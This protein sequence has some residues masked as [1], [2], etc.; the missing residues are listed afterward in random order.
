MSAS[1]VGSL[2]L[3]GILPGLSAQLEL[4]FTLLSG[5]GLAFEAQ[6]V[7]EVQAQ[8]TAT[9]EA[10]LALGVS[11]PDVA[12]ALK[13]EGALAAIANLQLTPPGLALSAQ[14][15]ANASLALELEARLALLA[16]ILAP[17]N[18]ALAA[19]LDLSAPGV[20]LYRGEGPLSSV[21][22][23]V[24]ALANSGHPGSLAPST[25]VKAVVLLVSTA[26]AQ[27]S[28]SLDA[29]FAI[30]LCYNKCRRRCWKQPGA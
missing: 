19:R 2:S 27:A 21:L 24:D 6:L 29:V 23:E 28:A 12:L 13:V 22:G 4:S 3:A 9:I 20:R 7:A 16:A 26:D 14:I 11:L 10:G 25:F 18:A 8:L 1:F 17:V 15:A 5:L 30:G